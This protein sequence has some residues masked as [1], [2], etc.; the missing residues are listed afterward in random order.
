M[1]LVISFSKYILKAHKICKGVL[2]KVNF[3]LYH[4]YKI[5]S[6]SGTVYG[7]ICLCHNTTKW[8]ESLNRLTLPG[9]QKHIL[10]P[11]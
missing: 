4:K 10:A 7:F 3:E 8:V 9:K 6:V 5:F 1:S 11:A 2:K